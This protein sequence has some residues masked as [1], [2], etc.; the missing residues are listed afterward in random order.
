MGWTNQEQAA[1]VW[2]APSSVEQALYEAKVRGD[3]P[4]YYDVLGAADLYMMQARADVDERP[5]T[6]VFHPYWNPQTRTTCLAVY[7]GGML[8]PPVADPVYCVYDLEWF[9]KAWDDTDPPWLV[10]NPGSPCEAV[11]PTGPEARELWRFHAA[12]TPEPGLAKGQVHTLAV[13]GPLQGPVAFGLACGA[14]IAVTNGRYWNALAYHGIGY[15]LEKR[16]LKEWWGVDS[17]AEWMRTQERLLEADMV[18]GVWEFVL[19]L[20]HRMARDFAGPVGLDHWRETAG[21]II[22]QGA[23]EAAQPQITPDGV[24][25]GRPRSA[26][27]IDGQIAGVQRLIGRIARYEARFRADGLLPEDGFV[28]T[29]EGWDYGRASGMARWGLAAGYCT[30]AETEAAVLRAGRLVRTNYR[31]WE[32]FSAAYVLG[33]CLHFDEEEFGTWY[34][35]ALATHRALTTDPASPW[36]NLPWE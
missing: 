7:T 10:V 3:W 31:S 35:S 21:H 29:A 22:R 14:H 26:A 23:E 28:R 4:A 30:L 25:Q 16:T 34:E 8:P 36:R 33:R 19:G 32:D 24:T 1:S 12:R 5:R 2:T 6:T 11:L 20:R 17:R 18:S 13:G 9:A 15:K 27:E